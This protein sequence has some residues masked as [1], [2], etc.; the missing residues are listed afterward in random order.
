VNVFKLVDNENGVSLVE[1]VTA[2]MIISFSVIGLVSA[3]IY[4]RFNV[5]RAGVERK[6]LEVVH[7]QMDYWRGMR[8]R[9]NDTQPLN[10]KSGVQPAQ[11]VI[12]DAQKEIS[13]NMTSEI[14]PIRKDGSLSYQEVSVKLIYKNSLFKDSIGLSTKMYL[15]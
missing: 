4:G 12:V 8:E 5:E 9:T 10:V 1:S 11:M 15:R 2:V 7:G 13:G 14:S 6:A 3:F